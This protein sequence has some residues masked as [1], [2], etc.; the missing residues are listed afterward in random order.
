MAEMFEVDT[1]L[2]RRPFHVDGVW[3]RYVLLLWSEPE[4][5]FTAEDFADEE[6][7]GLAE[8]APELILRASWRPLWAL[9]QPPWSVEMYMALPVWPEMLAAPGAGAG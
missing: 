1:V 4:G 5:G 6:Q 8:H 3:Q 9:D 7:F 2:C